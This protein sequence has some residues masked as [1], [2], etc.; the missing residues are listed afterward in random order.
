LGPAFGLA[1]KIHEPLL[2]RF[3]IMPARGLD[4]DLATKSDRLDRMFPIR[5]FDAQLEIQHWGHSEP[6]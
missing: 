3:A 5:I 2:F 4:T 1:E 6:G